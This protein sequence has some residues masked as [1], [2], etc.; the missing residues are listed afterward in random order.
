MRRCDKRDEDWRLI[1]KQSTEGME[2]MCIFSAD[3]REAGISDSLVPNIFNFFMLTQKLHC[4][5]LG[6]Y[7]IDQEI[8]GHYFEVGGK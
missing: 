7:V 1:E 5:L 2:E 4:N 3:C 6:F 8:E